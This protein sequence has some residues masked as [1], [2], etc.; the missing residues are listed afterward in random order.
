M[1]AAQGSI[2]LQPSAL[3]SPSL[4]EAYMDRRKLPASSDSESETSNSPSGRQRRLS[5]SGD[6]LVLS[7]A[8]GKRKASVRSKLHLLPKSVSTRL[9]IRDPTTP[10]AGDAEPASVRGAPAAKPT[11]STSVFG[12]SSGLTID[13]GVW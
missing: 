5:D 4:R 1:N 12:G 8:E 13:T 2:R 3:D 9:R 11:E 7:V 6:M 10:R